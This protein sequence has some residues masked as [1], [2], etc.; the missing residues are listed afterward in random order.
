MIRVAR[1]I[2][3]VTEKYRSRMGTEGFDELEEGLW[4]LLDTVEGRRSKNL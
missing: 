4:L 3:A 2:E 1:A